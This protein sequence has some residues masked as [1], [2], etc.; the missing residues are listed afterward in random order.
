M[1][2]LF[3]KYSFFRNYEKTILEKDEFMIIISNFSTVIPDLIPH[4]IIFFMKFFFSIESHFK[5]EIDFKNRKSLIILI[6][7]MFY[8]LIFI[9]D[10]NKQDSGNYS[11]DDNWYEEFIKLVELFY[12]IMKNYSAN[13]IEDSYL[14]Y[15]NCGA[16]IKKLSNNC[17]ADDLSDNQFYMTIFLIFTIFNMICKYTI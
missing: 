16:L 7:E 11:N 17:T 12:I 4:Y 2:L 14:I 1:N 10:E 6:F 15:R 13:H 3:T 9:L 5:I 8:N